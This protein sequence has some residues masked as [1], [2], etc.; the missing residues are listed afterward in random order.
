MVIICL[1]NYTTLFKNNKCTEV[2]KRH[3]VSAPKETKG[4]VGTEETIK[5]ISAVP[6][7]TNYAHL[8]TKARKVS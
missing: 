8:S 7:D 1:Y 3:G 6:S 4:T 2:K 5:R